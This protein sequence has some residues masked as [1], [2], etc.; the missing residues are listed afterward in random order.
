MFIA[1]DSEQ[2][3]HSFDEDDYEDVITSRANDLDVE[4]AV[5]LDI[6]SRVD[7]LVCGHKFCRDCLFRSL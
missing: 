4:C 3:D 7:A 1:Q 6:K 5:C 2:S